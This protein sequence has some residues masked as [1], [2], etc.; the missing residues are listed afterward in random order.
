MKYFR[1]LQTF[2]ISETI[3]DF[4]QQ[5]NS[6]TPSLFYLRFETQKKILIGVHFTQDMVLLAKQDKEEKHK[7]G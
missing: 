1:F 5:F 4:T 3:L 6:K 7:E 2:N